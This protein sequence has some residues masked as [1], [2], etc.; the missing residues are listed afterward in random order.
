MIPNTLQQYI[1]ALIVI[2]VLALT[3]GYGL[4]QLISHSL[5]TAI[6]PGTSSKVK[7]R[8]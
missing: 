4:H 8:L 2:L 5:E 6:H 3:L 7:V 1:T